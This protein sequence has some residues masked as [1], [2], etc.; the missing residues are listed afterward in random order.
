MGKHALIAKWVMEHWKPA[1]ALVY[2]LICVFDFV[3]FPSWVGITRMPMEEFIRITKDIDP[4]LRREIFDYLSRQ[5]SPYTLTGGGLFHLSFGVL[6]TGVAITGPKT[7]FGDRRKPE[8]S[9]EEK[10]NV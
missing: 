2:T 5:Y 7:I 8:E 6:L 9:Q 4:S 3:V 1:C 10:S